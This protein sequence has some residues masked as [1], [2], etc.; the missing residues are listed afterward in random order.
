MYKKLYDDGI[1]YGGIRGSNEF[2][3][4]YSHILI[5]GQAENPEK[6]FDMFKNEV[7]NFK[8][9]GINEENFNRIKKKLYGEYVEQYNDVSDIA[10]MFLSDY[11]KGINSFDYVNEI[12]NINMEYLNQILNDI[13]KEEKW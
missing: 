13:F 7:K 3:K 4:T 5:S 12:E 9:N 6:V 11:F 10:G 2:S 1:I 8:A